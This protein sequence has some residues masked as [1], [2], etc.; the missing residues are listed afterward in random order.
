MHFKHIQ[1]GKCL[2]LSERNKK[3][4]TEETCA[5]PQLH[6]GVFCRL[7]QIRLVTCHRHLQANDFVM[8]PFIHLA[9]LSSGECW[10]CQVLCPFAGCFKHLT[11]S[12]PLK[13]RRVVKLSMT[14]ID[15][16]ESKINSKVISLH[17]KEA[18]FVM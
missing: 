6:E 4:K 3:L 15:I 9:S 1:G 7:L 10:S 8:A 16:V 13:S 11:A 18:F 14:A 5:V 2:S 12:G 17:T